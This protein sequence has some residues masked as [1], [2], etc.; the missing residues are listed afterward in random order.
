MGVMKVINMIITILIGIFGLFYL[1]AGA[2]TNEVVYI[3]AGWAM[4]TYAKQEILYD[5]V[6]EIKNEIKNLK[7]KK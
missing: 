6:R 3:A 7:N 2:R 1:F 5:D 4:L